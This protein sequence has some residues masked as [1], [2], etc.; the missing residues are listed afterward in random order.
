[1]SV[2]TSYEVIKLVEHDGRCHVS[3]DY[4]KG[5]LLIYRL[6]DSPTIFKEQL[7]GWIEKLTRQLEQYHRCK[8]GQC[9]RYLNPYSILLKED[10]TLLLLDLEAASNTFVIKNM[11]K[12]AMQK[13]FSKPILHIREDTKL[14]IDL[15]ALGKTIQFILANTSV[16]PPLS[17]WEEFRYLR[18]IKKCLG[19]HPRIKYE[20]LKQ[21]Q[22]ELPK[23]KIH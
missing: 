17:K 19:E 1:M 13:H 23:S 20:N 14:S 3:M 10:G 4:V 12:R 8:S 18:I 22:K 15:Y 16:K 21:V 9:Y 5:E 6:K 2:T 11:H 7:F